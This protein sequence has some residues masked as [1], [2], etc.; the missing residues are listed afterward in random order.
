MYSRDVKFYETIFPYKISQN[1]VSESESEVSNLNFFDFVESEYVSKPQT[2][3]PTPS[4]DN[5]SKNS[6][7]A[8]FVGRNGRVHQPDMVVNSDQAVNDEHI[9]QPN[10]LQ[11]SGHDEKSATPLDESNYSERNVGSSSD[12]SRFQNVF[13]NQVEEGFVTHRRFSRS[14]KLPAKLNDYVLNT[15]VRYGI[16]RHANHALLSAENC[17]F[18]SNFNKT[19]KRTF[20]EEAC[21]DVNWVNVMNE[22]L[23]ALHENDTWEETKLPIGRKP[24][25][26]NCVWKIKYK[27][28]GEVERYKARLMANKKVLTMKKLLVLW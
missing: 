21:N 27:S 7:E 11:P 2:H 22:D 8:T 6:E 14:S 17:C 3:V 28:I 5:L 24:I 25:S 12:G 18:V 20:Y 23:Y 15:K 26:S 13:P 10:S 16:N 19:A 1:S 4:D 9:H